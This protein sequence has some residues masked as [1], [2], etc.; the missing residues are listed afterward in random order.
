MS[1]AT[2]E[3]KSDK[4][5]KP[6]AIPERTPIISVLRRD[7]IGTYL[8]NCGDDEYVADGAVAE[9]NKGILPPR[10][11][12]EL[13]YGGHTQASFFFTPGYNGYEPRIDIRKIG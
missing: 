13:P 10:R 1:T 11:Q 12:F 5:V 3:R 4:P 8:M 6:L 2:R 9:Y 7:M